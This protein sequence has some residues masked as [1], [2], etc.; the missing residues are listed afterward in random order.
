MIISD[1]PEAWRFQ[2]VPSVVADRNLAV[3][4]LRTVYRILT[5]VKRAKVGGGALSSTKKITLT[6]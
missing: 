1:K 6:R 5:T 4:I 3:Q 2:E